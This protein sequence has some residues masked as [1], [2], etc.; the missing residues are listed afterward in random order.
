V[1]KADSKELTFEQALQKLE[2]IVRVIEQGE[3]GL[4][5]SIKHH[6]E[7][8]GL[9]RYCREKLAD[10]ER[11]IQKLQLA[12]DGTLTPGAFEPE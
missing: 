9:I 2:E 5:E 11:R 7:G 3:V 8:M 10:A 4:E 6:E 12:D 1:A